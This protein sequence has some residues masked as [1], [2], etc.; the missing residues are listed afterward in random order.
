MLAKSGNEYFFKSFILKSNSELI[1]TGVISNIEVSESNPTFI[2]DLMRS[3]MI[4]GNVL[5]AGEQ[6]FT[7]IYDDENK[8]IAPSI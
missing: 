4:N 5:I 8:K 3:D 7:K 1:H 2:D 6:K